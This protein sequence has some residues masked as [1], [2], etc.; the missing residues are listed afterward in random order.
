M[1]NDDIRLINC[2]FESVKLNC[3]IMILEKDYQ[4]ELWK[5]TVVT[6]RILGAI[7]TVG[8]ISKI[9]T[10]TLINYDSCCEFL[11]LHEII[12]KHAFK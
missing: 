10:K 3:D 6:Y 4:L 2:P 7:D 1:V 12:K 8:D 5:L 9:Y 11:F